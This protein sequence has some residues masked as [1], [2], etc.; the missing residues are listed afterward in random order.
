VAASPHVLL[1]AAG[2]LKA[3]YW[4]SH[5]L[6]K[7]AA[8][9]AGGS[10]VARQRQPLAR[11]PRGG[12]PRVVGDWRGRR[13][14]EREREIRCRRCASLGQREGGRER[15][16]ERE[17]ENWTAAVSAARE[18]ERGREREGDKGSARDSSGAAHLG[19]VLLR[20]VCVRARVCA[21]ATVRRERVGK[22]A[23]E[24]RTYETDH[25]RRRGLLV[26]RHA[27]SSG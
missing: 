8:R 1:T 19:A 7:L 20:P 24:Q 6:G 16:R 22:R 18:G 25:R 9:F 17:R 3:G 26:H 11:L 10:R 4:G 23:R 2:M 15:E 13:E 12:A 21:R 14:R 27:S 5:E